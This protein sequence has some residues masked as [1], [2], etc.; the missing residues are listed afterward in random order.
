MRIVLPNIQRESSGWRLAPRPASLDG[1]V[2]GFI[3]GW[4]ERNHDGSFGMYPLM[5]EIWEQLGTVAHPKD[6]RWLKKV[7]ISEPV[8]GP[9][10]TE[11][12]AQV[13]VVINGE[14]A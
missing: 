9:T 8:D 1:K 10:L 13:D 4:G 12:L 11:F 5:R 6:L 7:S 14:A 2:V 3:D